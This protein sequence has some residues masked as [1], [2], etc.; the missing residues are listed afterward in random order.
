VPRAFTLIE[1]LVVISII[2]VLV[3]LLLPALAHARAA[4]QLSTCAQQQ[5]QLLIAMHAYANDHGGRIPT[6]DQPAAMPDYF[7]GEQASNTLYVQSADARVGLGLLLAHYLDA[8]AAMFC[9]ADDTND[10][11]EELVKLRDRTGSAFASYLYR[12]RDR[13]EHDR[14][15]DLGYSNPGLRASALVLDLNALIPSPPEYW[16]TNHRNRQVNVG[17]HDGHVAELFNSNDAS[18]GLFSLR[19]ADLA[20]PDVR[21]DQIL[22]RADFALVGEAGEVPVPVGW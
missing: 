7:G 21:F 17:Y 15:G 14:L 19:T 22:I 2:A 5:R 12:Q 10:P 16:R 20:A 3:G 4:A 8:D 1:L 6:N 11:V 18:D 13:V 9:P